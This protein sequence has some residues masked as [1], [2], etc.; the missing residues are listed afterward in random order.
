MNNLI[1]SLTTISGFLAV[2]GAYFRLINSSQTK[3]EKLQSKVEYQTF[4]NKIDELKVQTIPISLMKFYL[5]SSN[6]LF[7]A[8]INKLTSNKLYNYITLRKW[9]YNLTLILIF[10]PYYTVLFF[11]PS[12][13]DSSNQY[14]I[15][16]WGGVITGFLG[17]TLYLSYENK[18]DIPKFKKQISY[19]QKIC[20][21]AIISYPITLLAFHFDNYYLYTSIEKGQV[22]LWI[23]MTFDFITLFATYII[24]K[25]AI[26]SK[27]STI[28]LLYVFTDI[29][30]ASIFS[31]L[32][33]FLINILCEFNLASM[34][35]IYGIMGRINNNTQWG[36]YS[37]FW[38]M[39]TTFIPTI[40]FLILLFISI[41]SKLI[42]L[43][44]SKIGKKTIS[45][46]EP[47]LLT[48]NLFLFFSLIFAGLSS[49]CTLISLN[50]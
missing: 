40:I 28:H 1:I 18:D 14:Y 10:V 27:K 5:K 47:N 48:S 39:H 43:P 16:V 11:Q 25:L 42:I 21:V 4:W 9:R 31:F 32:V 7:S 29:I 8:L 12:I 38:T 6:Q 36:V 50:L 44:I 34:D 26:K 37:L 35:I 46:D 3:N 49:L 19:L 45:V 22:V 13:F 2:V 23:N 41:V 24:F 33:A 17:S 30:L 20:L 15:S